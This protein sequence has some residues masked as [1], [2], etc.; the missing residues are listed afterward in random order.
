MKKKKH[1]RTDRL[2]ALRKS[3]TRTPAEKLL[4]EQAAESNLSVQTEM[5]MAGRRDGKKRRFFVDIYIHSLNLCVEID[6][7]Y[8]D[9]DTQRATDSWKTN[10]ILDKGFNV[11]RVRNDQVTDG[12]AIEII[13]NLTPKEKGDGEVVYSYQPFERVLEQKIEPAVVVASTKEPAKTRVP[14]APPAKPKR[15]LKDMMARH[16]AN[17]EA[18]KTT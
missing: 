8:H 17:V 10:R 2:L 15:I 1:Q 12:T 4:C 5:P 18:L 13:K 9:T 7:G 3:A 11:L 16:L 14:R 6:G